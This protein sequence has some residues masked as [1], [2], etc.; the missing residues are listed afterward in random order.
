MKYYL[1]YFEI[2]LIRKTEFKFKLG[3]FFPNL[4]ILWK[5]LIFHNY[6]LTFLI[7]KIDEYIIL[8]YLSNALTISILILKKYK[9]IIIH[10]EGKNDFI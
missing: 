7:Y 9:L 5:I 6:I 4:C 2:N 3:K 1:K 8:H 10:Y